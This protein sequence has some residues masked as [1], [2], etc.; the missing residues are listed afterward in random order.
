VLITGI[1]IGDKMKIPADNK[2][3]P[4]SG[5]YGQVVWI[6]GD[7]KTVALQCKKH[8]NGKKIVLIVKTNSGK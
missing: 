8:H 5:H 4:E 6:D 7:G 3:H 2:L 1:K